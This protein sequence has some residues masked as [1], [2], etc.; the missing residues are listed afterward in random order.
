[1]TYHRTY[2]FFI[3]IM[4]FGYFATGRMKTAEVIY[5]ITTLAFFFVLRVFH[6]NLISLT[7]S[8]ALYYACVIAFIV[9]AVDKVRQT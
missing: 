2:D 6:E 3:M 8:G 5:F 1:M 9:I 4:V 7:I